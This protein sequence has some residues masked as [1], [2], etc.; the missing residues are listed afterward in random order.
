MLSPPLSP[1]SPPLPFS[2]SSRLAVVTGAGSGIG[3]ALTRALLAR[4]IQVIAIDCNPPALE[5]A[6]GLQV[7]TLDVSDAAAMQRLAD[8]VAHRPLHYLFA[9]AGIGAPGSVLGAP[10]TAWQRAWDVNV[11][12]ALVSLRC[13][14]PHL[15]AGQGQAVATVSA[16]A[17]QSYPGAALYRATKA[18]LL[19]VLE[20]LYYE[21][22]NSGVSVHAL[23][24]GLVQSQIA[25]PA[26]S[27]AAGDAAPAPDPFTAWVAQALLSAEPAAHFAER[28][29]DGLAGKPPFYWFTHP[30]TLPSIEGRHQAILGGQPF[31]DFGT[32]A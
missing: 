3:L 30:E 25:A 13:W 18:A 31:A 12:G 5:D 4:Q 26:R 7:V 17:L 23:C 8:A 32:L 2:A 28:V 6:P 9:N 29:L 19:A 24:P 16:A 10:L 27:S 21:G 20:G 22:R 15:V 11:M 1:S 14:W